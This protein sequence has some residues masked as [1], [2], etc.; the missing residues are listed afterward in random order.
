MSD[1]KSFINEGSKILENIYNTIENLEKVDLKSYDPKS[2]AFIV[3]DMINGFAREGALKSERVEN[4]I[5]EIE[6]LSRACDKMGITKIAFYDCHGEDS[7]EFAA[8]PPHCLR[9]TH[10]SELVDELKEVGGFKLIGKNST[11]GFIEDDF[12]AWLADNKFINKFILVGDCTDICILQFALSLMA[13]GNM[14]NKTFE[15]VVPVNCVD[16]FDLGIHNAEFMNEIALFIMMSNG[17]KIIK[18]IGINQ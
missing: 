5:P 2:A 11:N 4:L 13:Y 12:Q 7:P 14:M 15:I 1:I 3:V 8:Y 16:T 10:E 9:G 18:S 6:R 17:I